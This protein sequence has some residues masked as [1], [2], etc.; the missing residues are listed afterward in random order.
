MRPLTAHQRAGL[1]RASSIDSLL[2]PASVPDLKTAIV[3]HRAPYVA[4]TGSA[5]RPHPVDGYVYFIQRVD[6]GPIKI[7]RTNQHPDRRLTGLQIASPVALRLLALAVG[8]DVAERNLHARFASH[9]LRGEWFAPHE[10]ILS[11]IGKLPR[12][13]IPRR[14]QALAFSRLSTDGSVLP[15]RS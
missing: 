2:D 13:S 4:P 5:R 11:Y 6:G 9:R 1:E 14:A 7:G 15:V 10:D 8:G 3:R 12:I